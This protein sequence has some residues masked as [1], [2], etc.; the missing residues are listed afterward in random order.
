MFRR[1]LRQSSLL[2]EAL[3]KLLKVCG[4]QGLSRDVERPALAHVRELQLV[5]P[6]IEAWAVRYSPST[7]TAL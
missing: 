7:M 2:T 5:E 6:W 3:Q 1:N 4:T